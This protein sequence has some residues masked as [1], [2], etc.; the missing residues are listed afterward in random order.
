MENHFYIVRCSDG[1]L[2]CGST[3]NLDARIKKH[4]DGIGAKYTKYRRPVKLVYSEIFSTL[5]EA[6]RRERQVKG[7][8]REKKI[9][10]IH[11]AHP[12]KL[13]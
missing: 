8:R 1:S 10:L 13:K 6:Q 5:V 4:N 11:Y 7:W 9:N 2:Y 12:N 3:N